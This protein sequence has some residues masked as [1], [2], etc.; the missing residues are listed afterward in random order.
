M[1]PFELR[2]VL[3]NHFVI[4]YRYLKEAHSCTCNVTQ[5][6]EIRNEVRNSISRISVVEP[7]VAVVLHFVSPGLTLRSPRVEQ[8]AE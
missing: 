1:I 4:L 8:L 6:T 2:L 5:S 7:P 3:S